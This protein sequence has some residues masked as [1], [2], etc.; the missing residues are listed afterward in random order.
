[1]DRTIKEPTQNRC[2]AGKSIVMGPHYIELPNILVA[3]R[4]PFISV[5]VQALHTIQKQPRLFTL[6]VNQKSKKIE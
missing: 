6:A 5:M 4:I 3:K 2:N 1:M